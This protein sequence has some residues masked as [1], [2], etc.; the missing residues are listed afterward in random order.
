MD[1]TTSCPDTIVALRE[2]VAD[3]LGHWCPE[4]SAESFRLIGAYVSGQLNEAQINLDRFLAAQV[5]QGKLHALAPGERIKQRIG[6]LLAQLDLPSPNRA[7][8]GDF[9]ARE[10]VH[11]D[12]QAVRLAQRIATA[13]NEL[14]TTQSSEWDA[15]NPITLS[16]A[17][18]EPIFSSREL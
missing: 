1:I 18:L 8:W 4:A 3:Y 11:T 12:A 17:Q 16:L 9:D 7:P 14:L 5:D 15:N 6:K 13:A 2:H 10:M